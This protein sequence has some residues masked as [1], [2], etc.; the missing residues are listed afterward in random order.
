M[1]TTLD[2]LIA[3][4]K[5][6]SEKFPSWPTDPLHAL[7][8]LGEEYGELTKA[9]LETVYEPEK[10][11]VSD[12]R[13]EAIQTAAM[14]VRFL[15]SID[16]YRFKPGALHSQTGAFP[17][18]PRMDRRLAAEARGL[19]E[20]L[21]DSVKALHDRLRAARGVTAGDFCPDEADGASCPACDLDRAII[22]QIERLKGM[23]P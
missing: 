20:T 4:I 1:T 16:A 22:A 11:N 19:V 6:A 18:A 13:T 23:T 15:V 7:A 21:G 8:V 2:D 14:A 9:V 17:D 3:E 10:S 5:R 12:V